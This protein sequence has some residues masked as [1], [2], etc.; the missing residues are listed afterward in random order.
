MDRNERKKNEHFPVI[1]AFRNNFSQSNR[2]RQSTGWLRIS[3]IT[4]LSSLLQ[5][6]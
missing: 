5:R 2:T 6:Q 1:I 3:T 4:D